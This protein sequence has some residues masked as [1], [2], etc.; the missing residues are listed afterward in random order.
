LNG[1]VPFKETFMMRWIG[2]VVLAFTLMFSGSA[3]IHS[4]AAQAHVQKSRASKATDPTAWHRTQ[5]YAD[6]RY[7][8][9][10]YY[11]RPE[12]YRPYPYVLPAPF[13]FGL[14]FGPWW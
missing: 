11:D 6:R 3:A 7:D 10:V 5:R 8:R 9:P 12:T 14:G 4:A 2:A 13:P 1:D